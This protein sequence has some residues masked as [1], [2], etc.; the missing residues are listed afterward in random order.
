MR[1]E[2]QAGR[3]PAGWVAGCVRDN[4]SWSML[5]G[6]YF[7]PSDVYVYEEQE[8]CAI[9]FCVHISGVFCR[10]LWVVYSGY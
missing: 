6:D 1:C 8:P 10:C 9:P 7:R 5:V 3:P 2:E 4:G